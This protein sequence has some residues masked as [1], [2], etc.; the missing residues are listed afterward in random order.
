MSGKIHGS[1]SPAKVK[2]SPQ[3]A[4]RVEPTRT[5]SATHPAEDRHSVTFG[6]I[7]PIPRR[8]QILPIGQ[9][10]SHIRLHCPP[11]RTGISGTGGITSCR[12]NGKK[13]E[14]TPIGSVLVETLATI[15]RC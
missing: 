3:C 8:V 5:G 12:G 15:G 4:A 1:G 7:W 9:K 11:G 13:T 10:T 2:F 14:M 6:E